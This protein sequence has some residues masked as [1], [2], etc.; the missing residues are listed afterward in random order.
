[1]LRLDLVHQRP[2]ARQGRAE[3]EGNEEDT[4]REQGPAIARASFPH[5]G[6]CPC[7]RS[8]PEARVS[9]LAPALTAFVCDD[10]R[11]LSKSSTLIRRPAG[12][13]QDAALSTPRQR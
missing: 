3:V 11:W 4:G 5:P 10:L 12:V 8:P 7:H 2:H 6:V 13:A 1:G 9:A